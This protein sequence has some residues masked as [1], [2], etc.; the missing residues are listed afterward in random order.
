MPYVI[1]NS[2]GQLIAIVQD[3]TIN[4]TS[5]TQTLV[6][7]DVSPYGE[8]EMENLVHQLENF[9]N[10]TPPENP[11]QGQIWYDTSTN[12]LYFYTITNAWKPVKGATAAAVAPTA[13]PIVGDLWYDTVTRQ[14]K[15]YDVIGGT[16]IW[17]PSTKVQLSASAPAPI[18]A[19]QMYL[20]T[21][22]NQLFVYNGTTWSLIGPQAVEN[23]GT[24][25][26]A[27]TEIIDNGSN[28]HA[29]MQGFVEG[30]IQAI[31]AADS[32]TLD[33]STAPPGF[34]T[35]VPG[36]NLKTGSL[37]KGT[38]TASQ[39]L[40]PGRNINGVLFDGTQNITIPTIESV[41]IL[42]GGGLS[43]SGSPLTGT[44][45]ITITNTGVTSITT[46]A[47][48]DVNQANGAVFITNTGVTQLNTGNGVSVNQTSGV[49]T[50]TNTGVTQ[51][52][53]GN[54]VQVDQT[55]GV[56]TVTNT[57]VTGI[58]TGNGISINQSTGLVTVT[59]TGVTGLIAGP[60][61]TLDPV[62]GTGNVT[63]TA[64]STSRV[65]ISTATIS[66]AANAQA[67]INFTNGAATYNL[68]QVG[69]DYPARVRMYSSDTAR[70]AD[71]SRPVGTDPLPGSGV[72]AEVV[73]YTGLPN[74]IPG[75]L[76]QN[77][78]PAVVGFT[79]D[80]ANTIPVRVTNNDT[81]TRVI[82][83]YL[84]MLKLEVA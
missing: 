75:A 74:L 72:I 12:I 67:D 21:E 43:V 14:L 76:T 46:G 73:T 36:I 81:V 34:T 70:T 7:K 10:A 71:A 84:K 82:T 17:I 65:T 16:P 44:G 61:I 68:L 38:A 79:E 32:F 47:G 62:G 22:T 20:R 80:G 77:M 64:G 9:A 1:N 13:N 29:I 56:V 18:I 8:L 33:P 11:I 15:I 45:N 52:N 59:N 58:A 4:T 69:S 31:V 23:F 40:A 39:S 51:L 55:S 42:N 49:V 24:T 19:G 5:T 48:V 57:G 60:N 50:I 37:L 54:G 53:T 78:T 63:I 28:P 35:V 41:G 66:L 6:G 27:S 26:W 3:G 83:V 30:G 2:R 25:Q